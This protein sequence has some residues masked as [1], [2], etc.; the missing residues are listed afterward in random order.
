MNA[1]DSLAECYFRAGMVAEAKAICRTMRQ[2]WPNTL[3]FDFFQYINAL[4]E[5]YAETLR[6]W[7]R[8][9]EVCTP[10]QKRAVY[11]ERGFYR[12]WIQD[13]RGS[14]ADL[15]RAEEMMAAMGN[16]NAVAQIMRL[17]AWIYLDRHELDSSRKWIAAFRAYCLRE[18][19]QSIAYYDVLYYELLGRI[20]CAEGKADAADLC[21]R[22]MEALAPKV[23]ADN[24]A[25]ARYAAGLLLAESWLAQGRF[26]DVIEFFAKTPPRPQAF[27]VGL[28]YPAYNMPFGRDV[29]ARAYAGIG[30]AN[31][32]IEE[33][34]RLTTFDPKNEDQL[35]IHPKYHYRLGLLYEQRG[36]KAKAAERYRKFLD[37]WK[38]ADPGLPEVEDA[39]KRLAGLS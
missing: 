1:Y 5:N 21:W 31:K 20:E 23:S 26:G 34:E 39:K 18:R 13:V 10:E 11:W 30:S 29:L 4:E 19:S 16:K 24:Q 14:L 3:P 17:R 27:R 7:D 33:Y 15:E 38:A 22:E 2:K 8:Q 35:L 9:L 12:G 36:L 6:L 37:L 28:F 25:S 32:A